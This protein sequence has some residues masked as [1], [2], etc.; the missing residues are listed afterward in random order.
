M[1]Y[2]RYSSQEAHCVVWLPRFVCALHPHDAPGRRHWRCN[3]SES[4][5][6]SCIP[7][8]QFWWCLRRDSGF[9]DWQLWSVPFGH[10]RFLHRD[11]VSERY[12]QHLDLTCW[13]R[14]MVAQS[15]ENLPA[16]FDCRSHDWNWYRSF[17]FFPPRTQCLGQYRRLHHWTDCQCLLGRMVLVP[18]GEPTHYGP[19]HLG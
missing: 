17:S 8:G 18:Q 7:T 14:A 5:V 2:A 10:P 4:D 6:A 15:P 12:V 19:S 1:L 9:S 16:A 13:C 11:H 3:P